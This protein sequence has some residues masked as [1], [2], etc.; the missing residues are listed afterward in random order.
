MSL[1]NNMLRDLDQR[2]K[3]SEISPATVHLTPVAEGP[4]TRNA[5]LQMTIVGAAVAIVV[6]L[7]M[8]YLQVYRS[9][10]ATA[11][12]SQPAGVALPVTVNT[13]EPV[14]PSEDV[15]A[16]ATA[17]APR[18]EATGP[19][20]IPEPVSTAS[21]IVQSAVPS[22]PPAVEPVAPTVEEILPFEPP[23]AAAP[24]PNNTITR[25][26]SV[27]VSPDS[28]AEAPAASGSAIVRNNTQL[29]PQE[30]DAQTVQNALSRFNAS[31]PAAAFRMLESFISENRDAHQSRET[32]AKLLMSLGGTEQALNLVDEGLAITPNRPGYKKIK[33]RLMMANNDFEQA[34]TLLQNRIP[35]LQ[36]DV[37]YHDLLATAQLASRRYVDATTTYTGLIRQDS[38]EGKWWYGLASAYEGVGDMGAAVQAYTQALQSPTLSMALRQRSQRRIDELRQ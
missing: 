6:A 34:A 28:P 18:A 14:V 16:L 23:V 33:A 1:V 4:I 11:G 15:A 21:P 9:D 24:P 29:T 32:Y 38:S 12:L 22:L 19:A 8:F 3:S 31:D 17:S 10:P 36:E 27:R 13:A 25:T 20:P 30:R 35:L 37:E 7:G 26:P 2:R 5:V